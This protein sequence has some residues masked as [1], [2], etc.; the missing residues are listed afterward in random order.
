MADWILPS[1]AGGSLTL[2]VT[3]FVLVV[4]NRRALLTYHAT[5]D[6]IGIS[7]LDKIHREVSVTVGATRYRT[8]T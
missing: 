7:T 4:R 8:S 3:L 2:V 1:L 5:H 6:R